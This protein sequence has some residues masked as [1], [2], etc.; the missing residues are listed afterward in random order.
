MRRGY[1]TGPEGGLLLTFLLVQ[2]SFLIVIASIEMEKD[3]LSIGLNALA[4][5]LYL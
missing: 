5:Q 4:P 2:Y 1:L 3:L